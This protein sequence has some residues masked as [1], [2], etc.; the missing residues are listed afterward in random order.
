VAGR[1][2][3]VTES[4]PRRFP[5]GVVA[6]CAA[7]AVL[8]G[9]GGWALLGSA[10]G[11]DRVPLNVAASP[12]IAPS[13]DQVATRF[14][15]SKPKIGGFCAEV[16]IS[17]QNSADVANTLI[18]VS[19]TRTDV[20]VPDSS[21]WVDQVRTTAKEK[22]KVRADNAS[23]ASSPTVIAMPAPVATQ[24][25]GG[26]GVGWRRLLQ[27]LDSQ[28]GLQVGFPDP[29]LNTPGLAA[30]ISIG[31]S[32]GNTPQ[33]RAKTVQVMRSLTSNGGAART[34]QDLFDRLPQTQDS[35]A[36]ASAAGA[37]PATEQ[38]VWKY[39]AGRPA[40][41]L[42]AVYPTEGALRLDYPYVEVS[43]ADQKRQKAAEKFLAELRKGSAR[44][45]LQA[46]GF[47]SPDGRA[48][49][50]LK[51]QAGVNPAQPPP[52]KP[53]AS[54][55]TVTTALKSWRAVNLATRMLTLLDVSG[56]MTTPVPAVGKTRMEVTI[57]AAQQGLGL[58]QDTSELGLWTFSTQ[59]QGNQDWKQ[60]IPLG[61]LS[62]PVGDVT[63]RG[64][65]ANALAKVQAKPG[66]AT[67]LYDSILAAYKAVKAGY[68][69]NKVNSVLVFTDG[70]N[71]DPTGGISLDQLLDQ[72][73]Q[74]FDP[75]HPV[76]IYIVAFGP[77]TD[78]ASA[79]RISD[80][81]TGTA[82]QANT[83]GEITS[84]FLDAVGQR[85]CRPNCS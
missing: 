45:T 4:A 57:A 72:L 52:L 50:V 1:H 82:Y 17:P 14:N 35:Q 54:P 56:S 18:G 7:L 64:A 24:I 61:P 66:G 11:C 20:W 75:Q 81:T 28:Q 63:R 12:D 62:Q 70:R 39:N 44:K 40:V 19:G 33:A 73:K 16:R 79:R 29:T 67:G 59:L 30:L 26:G 10:A 38:Q 5:T 31:Q 74:L 84:V 15:K 42:V 2:R 8:I 27:E 43:G 71:E 36:I 83:P 69:P 76:P 85:Q 6:A 46:A 77:D 22:D 13:L 51:P 65:L 34:M 49:E 21:V 25:S 23:I 47:R 9:V 80:L 55:G 3:G 58:L 48:G 78:I 68:K 53:P 32:I 60:I 37:V 41:P